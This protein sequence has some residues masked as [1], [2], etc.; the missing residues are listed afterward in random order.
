MMAFV[1]KVRSQ[2]L[3]ILGLYLV[4]IICVAKIVGNRKNSFIIKQQVL[5]RVHRM[6]HHQATTLALLSE[7]WC[8]N[9]RNHTCDFN[10]W[11]VSI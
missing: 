2:S 6:H 10:S 9:G 1:S 7:P 5:D 4:T 8:S 3:I 11:L